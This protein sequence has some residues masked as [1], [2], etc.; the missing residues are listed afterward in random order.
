[1]EKFP[2]LA[3]GRARS[4]AQPVVELLRRVACEERI[5]ATLASLAPLTGFDFVE[6]ALDRFRISYYLANTDRENIPVDGR[7]VIVANHPLGAMDALALIHLVGSVRRDVRILA[8]DVLMQFDPLSSLLLPL[9]V[10]GAGS[11]L[12]GAREAYRA[13]E[14]EMALIVFPSGEVSRMR[15]TGVRDSAWSPGFARLAMKTGAPV[16]PVHVAAQNSPVFYGASMLAK[17]LAAILLAREMFGAVNARIGFN[18]GELVPCNALVESGLRPAAIA[19]Q[20]RRHV[21]RLARRRPA[22]F[23]TSA[24]IAHPESPRAVRS[25]LR[26]AERLGE[27]HD[28]KEILLLA[29]ERDC[30]AMREIG[31]LRELSFR[32]VGEGVG[33]RRDLDRFDTY[34]RHLVLWDENALAIVGA[35]R[36]GEAATILKERG[37]EGL[38]SSTLFDYANPAPAFLLEAVELGRSFVQPAYWN[39]RSL[40]AL[41]QGIG[42]YL[43]ARPDV[44]YLFGP[45]SLTAALP[46]PAREWIAHYHRHYFGDGNDLARARNP[47]VISREVDVAAQAEWAGR[48]PP[49]GLSRLRERLTALDAQLPVLYRQYVDLCEPEGVRFLDFGVDPSFGGCVDGLVRLDIRHLRAAKRARYLGGKAR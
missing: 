21:Y 8:N 1:Y 33:A 35:Y 39:A 5:N 31:R 9:P 40:D 6:G 45:V 19:S 17:P 11:P 13:L 29:A 3:A 4:L 38:Y 18:V 10:F 30:A 2:Q 26:R 16:L 14:R 34:Y 22:V 49:D 37:A 24:A 15:A 20:M 47:F 42:A 36:L 25:A 23:P 7:V 28:G 41:W 43:R 44:R 12:G 46:G 32:R 48:S 27:T